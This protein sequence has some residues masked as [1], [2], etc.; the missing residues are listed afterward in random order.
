[1]G[2]GRLKRLGMA[3]A[4]LWAVLACGATR[5]EADAEATVRPNKLP[6]LTS[7]Q[8]APVTPTG[9]ESPTAVLEE[10]ADD[11]E[12]HFI[13]DGPNRSGGDATRTDR[14]NTDTRGFRILDMLWPLLAVLCGIGLLFWALRKYLPG[15]RRLTGSRVVE[16]LARTYLSPRQSIAV[17]KV[18]RRILIVGQSADALSPLAS[19]SDPEEVSELVGLCA[20]TA[21]HSASTSFRKIFQR[22]DSEFDPAEDEGG[23][24]GDE[25]N[26]VQSEL[27]DL[28]EK[29]RRVAKD[30]E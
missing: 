29:V 18:G 28:T 30:R 22:M 13:D 8:D 15:M 26:R 17:V 16:I 4:M 7:A 5:V 9:D 19:V 24:D 25:L 2:S 1:M 23:A 21:P 3:A 20:S 10:P 14:G 6:A 27:D 11:P 12:K